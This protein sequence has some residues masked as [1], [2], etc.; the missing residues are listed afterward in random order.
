MGSPVSMHP[1]Q[2]KSN[3]I[4]VY[5]TRARKTKIINAV[6][7]SIIINDVL[8]QKGSGEA[9]LYAAFGNSVRTVSTR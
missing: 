7:T 3:Q 2:I 8:V 6:A 1:N 4:S 5:C 9:K